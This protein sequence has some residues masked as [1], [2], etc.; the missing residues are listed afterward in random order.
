ML[1]AF[2][3]AAGLNVALFRAF[4]VVA[5]IGTVLTAGYLLWMLQRVA[6]GPIPEQW[7]GKKFTDINVTEYVAWTPLIIFTV[8]L[9]IFP[10]IIMNVTNASMPAILGVFR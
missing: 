2:E 4:V 10:G 8:A 9:G 3:P 6:Q 1:A 5:A 7:A